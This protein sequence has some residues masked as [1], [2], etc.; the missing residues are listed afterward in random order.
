M[1]ASSA[2]S[3]S[4]FVLNPERVICRRRPS[5]PRPADTWNAQGPRH[6]CGTILP[7]ASLGHLRLWRWNTLP[8][9]IAGSDVYF[10]S[11]TGTHQL[12]EWSGGDPDETAQVQY[13]GGP[14]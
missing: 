2:A 4:F 9:R 8:R 14:L 10:R 1:A 6:L 12:D 7:L 13:R 3:A 5:A 11:S